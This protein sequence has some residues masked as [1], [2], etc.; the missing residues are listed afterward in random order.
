MR[1]AGFG[2][3]SVP[4]GPEGAQ[5]LPCLDAA[6][7]CNRLTNGVLTKRA[8]LRHRAQH[9]AIWPCVSRPRWPA[10]A[11][12]Q[13]GLH[14][15]G[16][17]SLPVRSLHA[18]L[19]APRAGEGAQPAR[20]RAHPRP[21]GRGRPRREAAAPASSSPR[22][23]RPA[24]TAAAAARS[25]S[26]ASTPSGARTTWPRAAIAGPDAVLLP[27]VESAEHVIGAAE[28]LDRPRRARAHPALGDDGD[29]ARHPERRRD[30]RGAPAARGLRPRHQRP[31]QGP[32]RRPHPRPPAAARPASASACSPRAPRASSASTAS[33]TP[34]RTPRGCA[35]SASRAATWASTARP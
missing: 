11:P 19:A 10:F 28:R 24:A 27:K 29:A 13:G 31:R 8:P 7:S 17:P 26:T 33:T 23:S 3:R 30:R 6:K 20:R 5:P 18:G 12:Q 9:R 25:A 4:C 1:A 21:R 2:M 22:R 15:A 35:P 14:A 32:R 34:S 16:R